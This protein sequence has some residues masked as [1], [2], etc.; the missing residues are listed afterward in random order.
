MV[1]LGLRG[2]TAGLG[3]LRS[4]HKQ[5]RTKV[6]IGG[7]DQELGWETIF[8]DVALRDIQFCYRERNN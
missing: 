3:P 8:S 2:G 7:L 5:D 6:L 1:V 4:S